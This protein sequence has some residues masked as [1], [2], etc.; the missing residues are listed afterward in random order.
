MEL[1]EHAM[2]SWL[3][4]ILNVCAHCAVSV[5]FHIKPEAV[6]DLYVTVGPD[7]L[8]VW[9]LLCICIGIQIHI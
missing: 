8:K 1:Q 9:Y 2:L 3:R 7:Y 5:L 6:R 4:L